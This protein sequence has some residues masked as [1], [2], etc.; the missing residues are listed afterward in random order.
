MNGITDGIFLTITC[1]GHILQKLTNYKNNSMRL[2]LY[3][4]FLICV[5]FSSCV[6]FKQFDKRAKASRETNYDA[7]IVKKDGTVI[8]GKS[9]KHK[10]YDSYDH[11]LVRVIN[12]DNA[13]TMDGKKYNDSDVVAFQDSKAF[14]KRYNNLYLI[15]LVKGKMNLYYFDNTGYTKTYT[16][17]NGPTSINS[18]SNRRS[19]FFF[20]K[21][22]NKIYPIGIRDFKEA[23]KDNPK[24]L[25][26]LN[27]YY[28]KDNYAK[29]LNIE[30]LVSVVKM[31]NQ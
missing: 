8:T 2:K 4:A 16:Y 28:P 31:Y 10:N 15:R 29:E 20:E 12:K 1:K 22:D 9:F 7:S 24:A 11:N 26:K 5:A 19:T 25:A 3:L 17:S 13:F 30:K 27:S 14:H 23:V 6:T 18:S 21:D